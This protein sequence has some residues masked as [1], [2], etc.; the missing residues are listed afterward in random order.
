MANN[1]TNSK[2]LIIV[3]PQEKVNEAD[4]A[5]VLD[6]SDTIS[7]RVEAPAVKGPAPHKPV[8]Y[9]WIA[10][11][12]STLKFTHGD[13][14]EGL[15]GSRISVNFPKAYEGGGLAWLEPFAPGNEPTGVVPNGYFLSAKGKPKIVS[16][17]WRQYADDN[18]GPVITSQT[19]HFGQRVQL[20]IYTE[21][22][23]GHLLQVYLKDHDH[24]LFDADDDLPE[25]ETQQPKPVIKSSFFSAKVN[26][27]KA[28]PDEPQEKANNDDIVPVQKAILNVYLDEAWISSA[29]HNLEV[30]CQVTATEANIAHTLDQ[31]ILYVNDHQQGTDNRELSN[32]PVV[33]GDI[34]T[35]PADYYPCRYTAVT[36]T[37]Q[38]TN[39]TTGKDEDKKVDL[40]REKKTSFRNFEIVAGPQKGAKTVTISLEELS[41]N[42]ADCREAKG[43]KH[44]GHTLQLT[45][46]P[47]TQTKT[48][49][50][51]QNR[52]EEKSK[53]SVQTTHETSQTGGKH[54]ETTV[55]GAP[56]AL[57][58]LSSTDQQLSFKARYLY[59]LSPFQIGPVNVHPIFRYFWLGK[60]AEGKP[61]VIAANTC[62][63][64]HNFSV[65]TYPDVKW[66][67]AF[68]YAFPKS[69]ITA[70]S[71]A[72]YR[73]P[74]EKK[75]EK[76]GDSEMS[77]SLEAEW[78]GQ[79]KLNLTKDLKDSLQK[80][81]ERLEKL[82]VLLEHTFEGKENNSTSQPVDPRHQQ[83]LNEARQKFNHAN[84]ERE[85]QEKDAQKLRDYFNSRSAQLKNATP[86]SRDYKEQERQLTLLQ[87]KMDKDFPKL[88]R[89]VLGIEII[90][91]SL[92][93][94]FSWGRADTNIGQ[95]DDLLNRT[96]ILLEG[97]FEAKPLIGISA[98]LD[99]LGLLQRAHPIALAVIAVA[100]LSLRLIGDGSSITCE[101]RGT[102]QLGGKLQGFLNTLTKKNSFNI[103]DQ[104]SNDKK[105]VELTGDLSFGLKIS[106]RLQ[107]EKRVIGARVV[108]EAS[109]STEAKAKWSARAFLDA[110][111]KG[112]FINVLGKF[113]GLE[114]VAEGT[115]KGRIE[116]GDGDIYGSVS[117]SAQVKYQA[118]DKQPEKQ[119]FTIHINNQS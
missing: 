50:P 66:K 42:D 76:V 61:Y 116:S 64:R 54:S 75:W 51:A 89:D 21:A 24:Y 72:T 45:S 4:H 96:G 55:A 57:E 70:I 15:S 105:A 115:I 110:E 14:H 5:V 60:L 117:E 11:I 106:I 59:D 32:Q 41:V 27:Y 81:L 38:M 108:G 80:K 29:G 90:K 40:Y 26:V 100:D 63:H 31:K 9:Q 43:K 95:R 98:F 46:W 118:I 1:N 12:F 91:P 119:L 87:R 103:K 114:I 102:G 111:E 28:M 56:A 71:T 44:K 25:Y 67:L 74:P 30:Y 85:R 97:S 16:A 49:P 83:I 35:S 99:F 22:L 86:G 62:R 68:E 23:Y 48:V 20:H 19:R 58:I 104:K 107:M 17:E 8:N 37:T 10:R 39:N 47:E 84:T 112:Y 34:P 53:W 65:I 33:V 109:V 2:K 92:S 113:D 94:S 3:Y 82:I 7:A 88:K 52:K 13:K 78:D 36:L 79:Q 101:L 93:A 69:K 18:N 73:N 77:L 6:Q